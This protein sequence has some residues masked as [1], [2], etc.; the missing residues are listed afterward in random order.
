MLQCS[1]FNRCTRSS[2]TDIVLPKFHLDVAKKSFYYHGESLFNSLP[3]SIKTFSPMDCFQAISAFCSL[4][5]FFKYNL[6]I[7]RILFFF[8]MRI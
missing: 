3:M 2:I 8:S 6:I 5:Q 1:V 7:M 4:E